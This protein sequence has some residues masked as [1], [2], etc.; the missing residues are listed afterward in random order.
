MD[1][2][3]EPSHLKGQGDLAPIL[4][5]ILTFLAL[6]GLLFGSLIYSAVD[7]GPA[8]NPVPGDD[9]PHPDGV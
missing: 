8:S 1:P 4:W 3:F 2:G 5:I 7:D 9:H 6:F